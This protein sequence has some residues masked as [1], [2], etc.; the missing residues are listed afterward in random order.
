MYESLKEYAVVCRFPHWRWT[1]EEKRACSPVDIL[2]IGSLSGMLAQTVTY[3]LD[4]IK[5]RLQA[6]AGHD[7]RLCHTVVQYRGIRDCFQQ[8]VQQ[9]GPGA[10]FRGCLT[11]LIRIMP[12]SAI[13]FTSYEYFKQLALNVS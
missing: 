8:V 4:S 9:E 11:N 7:P 6:Q 2:V 12:Y 5:K 1:C 10:L 3:P 13:M